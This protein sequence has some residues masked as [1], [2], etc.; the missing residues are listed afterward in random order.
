MPSWDFIRSLLVDE[1]GA[2]AVE[3]G[4]ISILISVA[5]LGTLQAL[6]TSLNTIFLV[7]ENTVVD[8]NLV[9]DSAVVGGNCPQEVC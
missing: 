8:A 4:I 3:Y 5:T 2:T 1:S 7:I 9:A 6:G